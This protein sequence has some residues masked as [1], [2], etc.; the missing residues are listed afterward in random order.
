[1]GNLD[2]EGMEQWHRKSQSGG[3]L[4]NPSTIANERLVLPEDADYRYETHPVT[5][6][7]NPVAVHNAVKL[8]VCTLCLEADA[9]SRPDP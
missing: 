4:C 3:Y 5:G 7:T 2:A 1:M 6:E 9:S 8:R